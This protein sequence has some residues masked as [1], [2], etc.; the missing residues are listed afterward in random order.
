MSDKENK[1]PLS[2]NEAAEEEKSFEYDRTLCSL[3]QK[4]ARE[5]GS[6]YCEDCRTKMM[7]T[8]IK[9]VPLSPRCFACWFRCSLL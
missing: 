4:K 8:K 9:E 5:E 6:Y 2:E 7:K 3:C 1:Q